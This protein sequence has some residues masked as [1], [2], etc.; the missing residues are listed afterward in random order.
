MM[1]FLMI[2]C[3]NVVQVVT[4]RTAKFHFGH[5]FGDQYEDA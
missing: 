4:Q 3:P 5:N 1:S 2:Y